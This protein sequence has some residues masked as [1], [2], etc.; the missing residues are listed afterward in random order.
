MPD[1]EDDTLDWVHSGLDRFELAD[2]AG[3]NLIADETGREGKERHP[4]F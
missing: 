4:G 3:T 2:G 1:G